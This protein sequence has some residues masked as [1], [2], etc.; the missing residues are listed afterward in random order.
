MFDILYTIIIYPIGQILEFIFVFFQKIFREIGLS[1]LGISAAISL[2]SLPL[3]TVAEK[4]QKIER[5]TKRKL[6]PK[7]DTIKAVFKGDEQYMILSVYYRQNHYHPVYA[8]RSTFGLLIQI[9]FFIAA[10]SFLSHLEALKGASFFFVSDMSVPDAFLLIGNQRINFLPILMTVLNCGSAAMYARNFPTKEKLQLYLIALVF[11][12]LLYNAPSGLVIYWTMNNVFSLLKNFYQAFNF[13]YKNRIPATLISVVCLF[14]LYYILAIHK[15]SEQQRV[16]IAL[17]SVI[18]AVLPWLFIFLRKTREKTNPHVSGDALLFLLS[19]L[20]LWALIGLWIPSTLI[21]SSSDEFSYIDSYASPIFFI[22]NTALQALGFLVFWPLCLYFLFSG[23]IKKI[24][25][26]LAFIVFI[27][28]LCNV[29]GFPG[30]YGLISTTLQFSGDVD[31]SGTETLVN[32]GLLCGIAFIGTFFFFT[33][34]KIK[35]YLI[36]LP[37]IC[38]VVLLILSFISMVGIQKAYRAL[39]IIHQRDDR[40][41]LAE[42][43]PLFKLSQTGRNTVVIM[44]D[45][46]S[47]S[48]FPF[49]LE[50]DPALNDAYS[51]FI[52]YPNTVSFNGYTHVGAP[53]VFGGYEYTPEEINRRDTEPLLKKHNEALLL[54]PTL[55]SEAGFMVTVTDP[56][57]PN[58]STRD[59]LSIYDSLPNVNAFITDSA[60]T[61]LWLKE[62]N[63]RLPS[64][65]DVLKRDILWYSLFRVLPPVLRWSIY[66]RG[67]WCSSIP[68]QKIIGMLNGYAV[69]DCLPRLTEVNSDEFDTALIMVNNTTHEGALLQAPEYRPAINVSSYGPSPFSK[70]TEYHINIAAFKRLA[71]WF[72]YLRQE[73]LYDNTRIILVSDHGSQISYVTKPQPRMPENFDNLHPIL[74]VKDFNASGRLKTDN[75]FMT[76]ADVPFLALSGQ[77][78]NPVNPFTGK[79]MTVDSKNKP[80]Y[81]AVSASVHRS[82]PAEKKFGL[83]PKK[84]FYVRDNIFDPNNWERAEN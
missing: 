79:E 14:T 47:S 83:D 58:Y 31:H 16:V 25:T 5:D 49:I 69:L 44:L 42:V 24:F 51:G 72:A 50:E 18:F 63:I 82:S 27:S 2:L 52:Y 32:L 4:W 23:N 65:S 41:E 13:K 62:N 77:I 46:A 34:K 70:E 20:A 12:V 54:L 9:P 39:S 15:G 80:L 30:D 10:Y 59:D 67:D 1:V 81:I 53:P 74:L 68:G 84:D 78:E 40:Q 36:P 17:F 76:N 38:A 48:F 7:I 11:L 35:A 8:M 28:A 37:A 64:V 56:P 73:G 19:L 61:E 60:Y 71:D 33:A 3:Y 75:A 22:W 6:K 57:Y 21:V 43:Q 66:Q 29:F 55:F 26:I 45:R